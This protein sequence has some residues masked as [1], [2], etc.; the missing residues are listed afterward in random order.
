MT[1]GDIRSRLTIPGQIGSDLLVH[2]AW[3]GGVHQQQLT[4]A[5]EEGDRRG[6]EL[7]QGLDRLLVDLLSTVNTSLTNAAC[8]PC[9]NIS[10]K[11]ALFTSGDC[12][13]SS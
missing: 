6:C 11:L 9:S 8:L 1:Q 10:L 12:F 2:G 4:G 5:V 7:S 13:K 3:D